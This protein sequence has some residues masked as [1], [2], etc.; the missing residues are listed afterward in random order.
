M[1]DGDDSICAGRGAPPTSICAGRFRI[2][3]GGGELRRSLGSRRTPA[4]SLD[5]ERC[6]RPCRALPSPREPAADPDAAPPWKPWG[7]TGGAGSVL[8]GRS[9]GARREEQRRGASTPGMA[10]GKVG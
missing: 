3:A 6:S 1:R 2:E 4:V 9:R 8:D 5:S 10:M 7:A